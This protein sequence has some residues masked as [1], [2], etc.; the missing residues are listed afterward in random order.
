MTIEGVIR[1]LPELSRIA[2][3]KSLN[4]QR[5]LILNSPTCIIYAIS[6]ICRNILNGTIHLSETEKAILTKYK[7]SLRDLAQKQVNLDKRKKKINQIGGALPA[8]LIP[9]I[10]LLGTIIANK[11]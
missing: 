8:L 3:A 9:A 4:E 2:N 11:I 5:S 7:S 6:E 1:C 10:T